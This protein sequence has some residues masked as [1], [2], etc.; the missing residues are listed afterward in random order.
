MDILG[1][2]LKENATIVECWNADQKVWDLG[3]RRGLFDGEVESW[4]RLVQV[5]DLVVLGERVDTMEWSLEA[6]GKFTTKSTFLK[7]LETS[8]KLQFPLIKASEVSR[9][10]KS[11]RK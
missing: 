9:R 8:P 3:L 11:R 4:M 7:L 1:I 5:L 6:D 2:S 10:T